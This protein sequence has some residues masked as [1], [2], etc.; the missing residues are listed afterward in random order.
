MVTWQFLRTKRKLEIP[1]WLINQDLDTDSYE[2]FLGVLKALGVKSI[3]EAQYRVMFSEAD[4]EEA[5]PQKAPAKTK[6]K[7]KPKAEASR[8]TKKSVTATEQIATEEILVLQEATTPKHQTASEPAGDNPVSPR[9]SP[10]QSRSSRSRNKQHKD[11][12]DV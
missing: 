6:T 11:V 4:L 3:E 5:K 9:K 8:P 2:L 1:A 12:T 7:I 10:S